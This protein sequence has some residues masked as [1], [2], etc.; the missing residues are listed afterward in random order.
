MP[1][2]PAPTTTLPPGVDPATAPGPR[3]LVPSLALAVLAF[4]MMQTLLV[5]ALGTFMEE[6]GIDASTAG[7]ILTAYLLVGAVAAPILGSFG[8]RYGHRKILLA[9]L[10]IFVI[11]SIT[12]AAAGN[13]AFLLLGR[14][15]QGVSTA[16]FPLALAIVQR[17]TTGATQRAYFGWLSGT[18]GLGAGVALVIGGLVLEALSWQWLFTIGALM[19]GAA[20]L[21][22][23]FFVP[24]SSKGKPT[25]TDWTGTALLVLG[26]VSLLLGIS[27]GGRWGWT[28]PA[29]LGLFALAVASLIALVRVEL[30][31]EAPLLDVRTLAR[32]A[33]AIANGLSLFLGFIPYLFYIG[34]P[35]LLQA[36]SASGVG[37]GFT[38]TQTGLALLPSALLVFLGGRFAPLL[39]QRIGSKPTAF[40]ALAIMAAGSIGVA[41]APG[42]LV[43]VVVFFSIVGLGNGIG[44][45]VCADLVATL[46]PRNEVAAA[47][48][49]NGVVRTVGSAL[50][51]PIA[52]VILTTVALSDSGST[53]L[54]SFSTL[55]F[56]A[57]AMGVVGALLTLGLRIGV[58]T[59]AA[60]RD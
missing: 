2:A 36:P 23:F 43:M 50:G 13:F 15:L 29:V 4:S 49:V 48:G 24:A 10:A 52:T 56:M 53:T 19:G 25:R 32:P 8:D 58:R 30:R 54:V 3:L 41:I 6:F 16:T 12:A 59:G 45:A 7:W 34:L 20:L 60:P 33:L 42:S 17:H 57:A 1:P 35:V 27:Q 18:L 38:V 14:V 26:L 37:Q 22:V 46:S 51:T 11:G 31:L 44:F 9:T 5:P 21:L 55:F 47:M 39:I 40:M 28:S